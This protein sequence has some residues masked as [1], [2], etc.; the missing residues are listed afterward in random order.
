MMPSRRRSPVTINASSTGPRSMSSWRRTRQPPLESGND[1]RLHPPRRR[2]RRPDHSL[3]PLGPSEIAI[4]R[5]RRLSGSGRPRS[6]RRHP[7]VPRVADPH[8]SGSTEPRRRRPIHVRPGP[9]EII[10]QIGP[11][12][13][14]DLPGARI[15]QFRRAK[16]G[17][18]RKQPDLTAP[19]NPPSPAAPAPHPA[20]APRSS[21]RIDSTHPGA[22]VAPVGRRADPRPSA[23]SRIP[24]PADSSPCMGGRCCA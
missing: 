14:R 5:A 8:R 13:A 24:R 15:G 23:F 3:R 2:H 11:I 18:V 4:P 21:W 19:P 10:R 9:P 12:L 17:C 6:G 7:R 16:S 22:G 20:A 1:L